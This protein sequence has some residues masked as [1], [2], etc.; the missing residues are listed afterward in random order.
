M[1]D[2]IL[3]YGEHFRF[4]RPIDTM[5]WSVPDDVA[6]DNDK[7]VWSTYPTW[8]RTVPEMYAVT[9]PTLASGPLKR[10]RDLHKAQPDKIRTF[11]KR[12]GVLQTCRHDLPVTHRRDHLTEAQRM[13][14]C[15]NV[16]CGLRQYHF[17][18]DKVSFWEP[19]SA[20]QRFAT[21]ADAM[22][23]LA[24]A[25]REWDEDNDSET[26]RIL[27]DQWQR[28]AQHWTLPD[29]LHPAGTDKETDWMLLSTRL[30]EWLDLGN[31]Q[32]TTNWNWRLQKLQIALNVSLFGAL[33]FQLAAVISGSRGVAFCDSCGGFYVPK[34]QPRHGEMHYCLECKK[35]AP[36]RN[37]QRKR[38][39]KQREVRQPSANADPST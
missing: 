6:I 14:D 19:L 13:N 36:S 1:D 31:I 2:S 23:C 5:A 38:R 20:W 32:L 18:R 37:S 24:V 10:F 16:E 9:E 4:E 29:M 12:W 35:T 17:S 22:L 33:A 34:Q 30:S 3:R 28:L 25:L 21:E 26:R 27:A 39:A 8:A 15:D 11:A 7:L